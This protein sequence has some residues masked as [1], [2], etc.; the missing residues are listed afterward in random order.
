MKKIPPETSIPTENFAYEN[1]IQRILSICVR[2]FHS[3]SFHFIFIVND[4]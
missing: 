3:I 2:F 1:V 4:L